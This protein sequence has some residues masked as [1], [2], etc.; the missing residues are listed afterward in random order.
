MRPIKTIVVMTPFSP[1]GGDRSQRPSSHFGVPG[2]KV[3]KKT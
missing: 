1:E 3:E 2:E